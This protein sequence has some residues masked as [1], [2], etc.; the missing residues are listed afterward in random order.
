MKKK[1]MNFVID[2]GNAFFAHETSINFNPTQF[3][4][5]FKQITPRLDPRAQEAVTM[6]MEHNVIMLEPFHAKNLAHFLVQTIKKYEDEF[7]EIGKPRA[8]DKAEE[9]MKTKKEGETTDTTPTYFG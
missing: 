1:P 2:D 7:G 6:R 4:L 8:V 5:D 9:K 3:I